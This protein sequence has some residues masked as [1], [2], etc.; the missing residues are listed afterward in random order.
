MSLK[1]RQRGKIKQVTFK[2]RSVLSL[3]SVLKMKGGDSSWMRTQSKAMLNAPFKLCHSSPQDSSNIKQLYDCDLLRRDWATSLLYD[4]VLA[5][6]DGYYNI[7]AHF[8]SLCE[9]EIRSLLSCIVREDDEHQLPAL[10]PV[11]ED[12]RMHRPYEPPEAL[13]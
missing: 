4:H 13:V 8:A 7:S 6:W 9:M 1:E 12:K 3:R 5:Y 11:I 10:Q 2:I